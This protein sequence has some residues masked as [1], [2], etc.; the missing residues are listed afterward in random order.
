[1]K[2]VLALS[3]LLLALPAAARK[4]AD[5]LEEGFKKADE[6]IEK[7]EYDKARDAL[8]EVLAALKIV[9]VRIVRYHERTGAAWLR[10]GKITEARASF[11]AALKATQRL[12]VVDNSG[13]RA[14]TGMGQCLRRQN[15]DAYALR[16]FKKALEFRLDEGTKMFAEDQIREIEG[17]P[18][19]SAR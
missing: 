16:F 12:K 7:G 2:T 5:P 18:P 11:A 1:M 9:D 8:D 15:K 17:T 14:Y 13:A 6:L 19:V 3:L 10:E 4:A